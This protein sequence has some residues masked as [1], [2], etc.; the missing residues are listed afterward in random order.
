MAIRRKCK[1]R[2][3]ANGRRCLEH[4]QLDMWYQGKRYRMM[5]N[6]FA[7]PRMVEGRRRPVASIEEARDW[8]RRSSGNQGRSRSRSASQPPAK[9]EATCARGSRRLPRLA[10]S[11]P[12]SRHRVSPQ[13]HRC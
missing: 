2:R 13:S 6:D 1:G 10:S 11:R 3:C 5:V 7:I 12:D 9:A 8:E 4:L